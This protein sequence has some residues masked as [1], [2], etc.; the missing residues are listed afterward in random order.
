MVKITTSNCNY[1]LTVL[2][3][4]RDRISSIIDTII[5]TGGYTEEFERH[6][7]ATCN[8]IDTFLE[9]R[10]N[11]PGCLLEGDPGYGPD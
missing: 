4:E 9:F 7:E 1:W 2:Y 8:M 6:Y 10:R 5:S 11:H 3:Q